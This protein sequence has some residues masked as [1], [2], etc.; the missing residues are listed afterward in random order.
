MNLRIGPVSVRLATAER[1]LSTFFAQRYAPFIVRQPLP[2]AP[3][4][5]ARQQ[6]YAPS[7]PARCAPFGFFNLGSE[8]AVFKTRDAWL[9]HHNNRQRFRGVIPLQKGAPWLFLY[10][11]KTRSLNQDFDLFFKIVFFDFLLPPQRCMAVNGMAYEQ[12][13]G[14]YAVCFGESE[15][16]KST[17]ARI[18]RRQGVRVLNDDV[19]LIQQAARGLRCYSSPFMHAR[20][21]FHNAGGRI[22]RAYFLYKDTRTFERPL[23]DRFQIIQRLKR[24]MYLHT[25]GLHARFRMNLLFT[26]VRRLRFYEYHFTKG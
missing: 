6:A 22:R 16:G 8:I 13:P 24:S 18:L 20:N 2:S 12:R 9:I 23:D 5:I 21:H 17:L 26:V 15:A 7:G 1:S 25:T 11:R 4:I 19:I 10:Q 3:A 14:H